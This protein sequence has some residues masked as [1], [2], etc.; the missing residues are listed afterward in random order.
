[1]A[2]DGGNAEEQELQR[3]MKQQQQQPGVAVSHG[4]EGRIPG[5]A[6]DQA[7]HGGH[8]RADADAR[9]NTLLLTAPAATLK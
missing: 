2:V 4:R 3:L 6:I 8:V 7:L 1:M 5:G 9:T